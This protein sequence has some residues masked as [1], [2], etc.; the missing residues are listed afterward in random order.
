MDEWK[1]LICFT[2]AAYLAIC[3]ILP[4]IVWLYYRKSRREIGRSVGWMAFGE[5]FG[6]FGTLMFACFEY[7]DLFTHIDWRWSSLIRVT[8]GTIAALTTIHLARS[9]YHAIIDY[10]NER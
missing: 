6:M 7:A 5:F 8:M 2:V 1:T 4:F 9:T 3:T 10:E